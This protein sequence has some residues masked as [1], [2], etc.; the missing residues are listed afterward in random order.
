LQRFAKGKSIAMWTEDD[1]IA[2]ATG[3]FG[4]RGTRVLRGAGDD[5]AVLRAGRGRLLLLTTDMLV[6]GTHFR[7]KWIRPEELGW[8]AVA[9]NVSDIAAM[10]GEPVAAVVSA[11]LTGREPAEYVNALLRGIERAAAHWGLTVAGGDTVRAPRLT[12]NVALLGETEPGRCVARSGAREGDAVVISGAP[13]ESLA[14]FLLLEKLGRDGAN[15]AWMRLLVRRHLMPEP[16][17]EAGRLLSATATAMMDLS[18]GPA[19]DLPRLAAAS[20]VG[21]LVRIDALPVSA[22]LARAATFLKRDASEMAFA[23]GEDYTL[24]FCA[25]PRAARAAI[26]KLAAIGVPATVAG[27][28]VPAKRGL[29]IVRP[30]GRETAWPRAGFRH[31]K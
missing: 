4:V 20:G 15:A 10:G 26:K 22:G 6:E 28:V 25:P 19:T 5:A 12:L 17:V 7:A 11:G 18:D 2:K 8:K 29:R 13:G 24:A 31:F 14:G 21:L 30:D 16:S 3:A 1:V 9:V 27:E 23:G